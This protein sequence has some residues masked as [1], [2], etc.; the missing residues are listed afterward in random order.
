MTEAESIHLDL[1]YQ[2]T[3][4]LGLGKKGTLQCLICS[5]ENGPS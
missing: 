3:R 1:K 4:E 2:L 5:D